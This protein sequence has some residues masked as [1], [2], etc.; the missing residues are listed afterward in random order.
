[1]IASPKAVK[2]LQRTGNL[3]RAI[4]E[5]KERGEY[6]IETLASIRSLLQ[7]LAANLLGE[8]KFSESLADSAQVREARVEFQ[9][10]ERA[11]GEAK[12]KLGF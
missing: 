12:E 2:E 3:E 11:V 1:V 4:V 5:T 6:I 7:D 9:R 10:V 8:D